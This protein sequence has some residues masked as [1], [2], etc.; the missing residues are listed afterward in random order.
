G[1]SVA[2]DVKLNV[3]GTVDL[4]GAD[5]TGDLTLDLPRLT[6]GGDHVAAANLGGLS[7]DTLTLHGRPGKGLLDLSRA[8]VSLL[9]DLKE[10][11]EDGGLLVLEGLEYRDI[12]AA[13]T[14]DG[15]EASRYMRTW[16]KGGTK[17]AREREDTYVEVGFTPQ[18][19]QQLADVYR[20]AGK[21]R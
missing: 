8:K 20:S 17:W 5:I 4:S 15:K 6:A 13:G 9:C 12:T 18:P 3:A 21:D 10:D 14:R 7:A 19:Y 16:L 11:R 2:R 1:L